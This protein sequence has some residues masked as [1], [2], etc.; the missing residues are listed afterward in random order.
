MRTTLAMVPLDAHTANMAASSQLSRKRTH[1]P[2][3]ETCSSSR[4]VES[5]PAPPTRF[6]RKEAYATGSHPSLQ[7][8][9]T[10]DMTCLL[11]NITNLINRLPI[12]LAIRPCYVFAKFC[13]NQ[14]F[15]LRSFY[16]QAVSNTFLSTI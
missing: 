3:S 16:P 10:R 13:Q 14:V 8:N 15:G 6:F 11:I 9:Q 5:H 4:R 1:R 12:I 2:G 7:H